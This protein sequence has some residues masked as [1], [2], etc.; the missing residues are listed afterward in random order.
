MVQPQKSNRREIHRRPRLG[1]APPELLRWAMKNNWCGY[2]RLSA[3]MCDRSADASSAAMNQQAQKNARTASRC[4]HYA[5]ADS[6]KWQAA[7]EPLPHHAR[8]S[9]QPHC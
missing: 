5:L 4:A 1:Q 8:P 7:G 6:V 3:L 9:I 2:V